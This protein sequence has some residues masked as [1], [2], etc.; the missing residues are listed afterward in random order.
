MPTHDA[1]NSAVAGMRLASPCPLPWEGL[2]ARRVAQSALTFGLLAL[3]ENIAGAGNEDLGA[4]LRMIAEQIE[5]MD[6]SMGDG[7][8][9]V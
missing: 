9:N 7:E 5:S 4:Q 2:T 8:A 3:S 6:G 1:I